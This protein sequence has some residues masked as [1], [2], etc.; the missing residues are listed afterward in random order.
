VRKHILEAK[1][2]I[3]YFY[4]FALND[5]SQNMHNIT[6]PV[7][8]QNL[9][10][11]KNSIIIMEEHLKKRP[12][13]KVFQKEE[14]DSLRN[15]AID[16]IKSKL[17]PDDKIIKILLIGS[18]VKNSFGEYKH[19]GFRGSLFSD[20]DFI[21]FVED[22]YEIPQWLDREPDGKPFPDDTMNL[23]YRN[24]KYIEDKYDVEIFFIRKSNMQDSKIQKLGELAGIPMIPNT[25]HKHLVVYSRK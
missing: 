14:I 17:L 24:K 23:A 3:N 21:V 10:S 11:R 22:D 19:P 2:A 8:K 15:Q 12:Q 4:F 18:S 9:L 5:I 6:R 20:F 7:L 1:P 25:E 16:K 13:K